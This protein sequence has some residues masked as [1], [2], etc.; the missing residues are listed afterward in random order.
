LRIAEENLMLLPVEPISNSKASKMLEMDCF[1][2]EELNRLPAEHSGFPCGAVWNAG[3]AWGTGAAGDPPAGA[4]WG[5]SMPEVV[6]IDNGCQ[7]IH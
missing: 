1:T 6:P 2:R 4:A 5:C 7:W 3:A